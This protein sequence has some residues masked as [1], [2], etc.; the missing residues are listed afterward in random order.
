MA[1][2]SSFKCIWKKDSK[3]AKVKIE[4]DKAE[5]EPV[6]DELA[7]K[8]G[9]YEN[10]I[11]VEESIGIINLKCSGKLCVKKDDPLCRGQF[12]INPQDESGK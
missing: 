10:P 11:V 12:A 5:V 2:P 6:E 4:V 8:T 7:I 1:S 9:G 3:L